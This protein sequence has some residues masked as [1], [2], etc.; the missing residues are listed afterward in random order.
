MME[1]ADG[2]GR[3]GILMQYNCTDYE[4]EDD[5]VAKLEAIVKEYPEHVYLAPN[6][7]DGKLILTAEGRR[8]ILDEYDEEKI[9]AFI[10]E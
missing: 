5:F 2:K 7:Y 3:P 6:T 10:G 8:E 9:R 1:H 4:C